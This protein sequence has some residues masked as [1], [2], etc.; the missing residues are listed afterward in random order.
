MCVLGAGTLGG[1]QPDGTHRVH[2][3]GMGVGQFSYL[4]PSPPP[5]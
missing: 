1:V 2:A 3:R 4:A 5:T